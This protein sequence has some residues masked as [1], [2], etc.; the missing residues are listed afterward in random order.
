MVMGGCYYVEAVM[1]FVYE[2]YDVST[3]LMDSCF[4]VYTCILIPERVLVLCLIEAIL[5]RNGKT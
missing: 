4:R 3:L 5:M 2:C 1:T